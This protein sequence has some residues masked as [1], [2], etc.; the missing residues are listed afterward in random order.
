MQ[1]DMFRGICL[2]LAH[3][4]ERGRAA[5]V[6]ALLTLRCEAAAD[7]VQVLVREPPVS[8]S[9][10][11]CRDGRPLSSPEM[12]SGG[13]FPNIF[14]NRPLGHWSCHIREAVGCTA[15][16]IVLMSMGMLACGRAAACFASVSACSLPAIPQ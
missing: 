1:Q 7:S 8:C 5:L 14:L 13:C 12:G 4:T 10:L 15:R 3:D 11:M 2:L 16:T 9:E 6:R